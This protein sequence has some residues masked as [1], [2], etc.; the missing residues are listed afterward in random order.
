[1]K[2]RIKKTYIYKKMP[3]DW[4]NKFKKAY[5][6]AKKDGYCTN[7]ATDYLI[8]K[9]NKK[10]SISFI[11]PQPIIGSGGHRNIYRIVRYLSN[12]DY[13]VTCYVDPENYNDPNS[14]KSGQEAYHKI[15]NNFFDLGCSIIFGLTNI[16]ECDVLFATHAGSAYTVKD[17]LH[18]TKL[19]CYFIQDFEPYFQPMG[20]GYIGALNTYKFGLYPITSGPWPLALLKRDFGYKR[21]EFFRFPINTDI[22]YYNENDF[23][24]N[25]KIVFFAKPSM[26]RRCYRLGIDALNLVKMKHPEIEI[27]LYGENGSHYKDVPFEFTNVGLAPKIEDL[28]NLYRSAG[29]GIAF[30]TTN[31]SLVPYEM[32]AC[33]MAV[34]DLDFNNSVVSY[35]SYDNAMLVDTTPQAVAE[36]I[37]KLIESPKLLA[38]KRENGLKFC[39]QFPSEDE[40]CKLIEGYILKEYKRVSK[41]K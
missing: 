27:I 21:G 29:I 4:K 34:V 31:P 16:K 14:V 11:I 28:G 38:Q 40:M 19:G 20:D 25:N 13:D 8:E 1:M 41:E 37:I 10:L 39:K 7:E 18:K 6:K 12:N 36:G 24:D 30:S 22:Y 2:E 32:M 26:P 17:N 3:D 5:H 35:D 23:K 9:K 33:G 15:T